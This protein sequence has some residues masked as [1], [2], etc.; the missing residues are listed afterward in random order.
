MRERSHTHKGEGCVNE[1]AGDVI[2]LAEILAEEWIRM[3]WSGSFTELWSLWEP[4]IH[5]DLL[6]CERREYSCKHQDRKMTEAVTVALTTLWPPLLD[7]I[8]G[9]GCQWGFLLKLSKEISHEDLRGFSIPAD[10]APLVGQGER[11]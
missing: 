4:T 8:G 10:D 7:T 1:V 9:E 2:Q 5:W 3:V 6:I 11:R